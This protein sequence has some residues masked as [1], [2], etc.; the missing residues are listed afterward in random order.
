MHSVFFA[1]TILPYRQQLIEISKCFLHGDGLYHFFF[2]A[3][4]GF[5]FIFS[6][7]Q[8]LYDHWYLQWAED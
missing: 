6:E 7:K 4:T 2:D 1:T 3:L 5:I 8:K